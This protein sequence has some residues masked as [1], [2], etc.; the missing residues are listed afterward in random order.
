MTDRVIA[1]TGAGGGLGRAHALA[2][3]AEGAHV[4]VNDLGCAVDGSGADPAVAQAV[5][6]EI[7]EAGGSAVA[8]SAD[9]ATMGG[10]QSLLDLALGHYGRLD[11]L[12][13]SAGVLRDRMFV[14]MSEDEWDGAIRNHLKSFFCPTRIAAAY[15]RDESK[16]GRRFA[17]S[18]VSMSSTSGLVGQ[19]GQSNYGAAKAAI[20]GATVI[21]A[22]ELGRYG[23]RVNALT[24]VARTRMTE[25][26]PGVADLVRAPADPAEFDIFDPANVSPTVAWLVSADCDITG[27]VLY[28][29]GGELRLFDGWRYVGTVDAGR[30][31][32]VAEAGQAVAGLLAERTAA[33]GAGS[34]VTAATHA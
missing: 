15:W 33:N 4:V 19:V 6:A 9:I 16:A 28:A 32:T 5:A 24:P 17:A 26:T 14:N 34:T 3:A 1:V 27:R 12:V 30:R 25:D 23:V 13:N 8:S 10:A 22:Q 21:L 29:K 7:T 11:G 20:A 2:L 31:M 18:V